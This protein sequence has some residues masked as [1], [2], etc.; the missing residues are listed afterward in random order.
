MSLYVILPF[1]GL[2]INVIALSWVAAKSLKDRTNQAFISFCIIIAAW[3]FIDILY[4]I[5]QINYSQLFAL[6]KLLNFLW[7]FGGVLFLNFISVL[8]NTTRNKLFWTIIIYNAVIVTSD[9]LYN[10]V[11]YD[12]TRTYWRVMPSLGPWYIPTIL[13]SFAL[14][15]T[16]SLY[17]LLINR[18]S[19]QV[20]Q[21][22]QFNLLICAL[23]LTFSSA[24]F[25]G[26]IQMLCL[27]SIIVPA[28]A[29]VPCSIISLLVLMTIKKYR[30]MSIEL[31]DSAQDIFSG[32]ND[33]VLI[34]DAHDLI[35]DVNTAFET[36]FNTR[37]AKCE[38]KHV[39]E[40]IPS[41]NLD[42]ATES[43][44][45]VLRIDNEEKSIL[46]SQIEIKQSS[47]ISGRIVIIRDISELLNLK[48]QLNHSQKLDSLGRLAGG[49]AHDFNNIILGAAEVLKD[50]YNNDPHAV[51]FLDIIMQ[52][53]I[54]ASHL[55]GKLLSFSRKGE[56]KIFDPF[57]TTKSDGNGLG[58]AATYGTIKEHGGSITFNSQ[59]GKGTTFSL[60]LPITSEKQAVEVESAEEMHDRSGATILIADDE[61][62]IRLTT[63]EML[64]QGGYNV[65]LARNGHEA[66]ELYRKN[67]NTFD[68]VILDM[69]MPKMRGDECFKEIIEMK[70]EQK[71]IIA[72]AHTKDIEIQ[73]LKDLGLSSFIQKP[74]KFDELNS[75]IRD[76]LK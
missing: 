76:L 70:P 33:A 18:P 56:Q 50:Q 53:S 21:R 35:K 54:R 29:A 57:F 38:S 58:L 55:I 2:I 36:L 64:K 6:T 34:T 24:T 61:E 31:I 1:I 27:D 41:L 32:V 49:V 37:K 68:I 66:L 4:C 59:V 25:I 16:I 42:N 72:S 19:E 30:L 43:Q 45:I 46:V 65:S 14:P 23:A 26:P 10:T 9:I 11:T 39:E 62:S 71:V 63:G 74:Y 47:I 3:Q 22:R 51:Q 52:A 12:L 60:L 40:F 15:V 28:S 8:T 20:I 7:I 44:E 69:L 73:Q 67:R 17:L 5:E 48:Q 13:I 75:V